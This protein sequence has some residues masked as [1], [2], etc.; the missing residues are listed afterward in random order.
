MKSG[1]DSDRAFLFKIEAG[2]FTEATYRED[3]RQQMS[4]REMISDG[5][6]PGI[7]AS[8]DEVGSFYAAN[9]GQMQRPL[10]VHARHILAEPAADDAAAQ[11]AAQEQIREILTEI[12]AGADFVE[13]ARER[14]DAPSA[15]QGGDL[16]FFGSGRMVPSFERAA[17]SLQ[18]GEVSD[19]VKTQF[20]YHLIKVEARRGGETA[21]IEEVADKI[22]SYLAQ[23]KLQ[24]EVETLVVTLRDEGD[25][26][27][28]LNL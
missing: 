15:P 10:E 9:I 19:V 17:F 2:G 3:I 13:L 24:E 16:G 12:R 18:P 7:T 8:D 23:Q 21:P 22:K 20:G 28:F 1:F 25:V 27:I 5:I 11:E 26:E 14:S 6:A 4:V